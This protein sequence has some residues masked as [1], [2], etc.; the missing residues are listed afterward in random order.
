MNSWNGEEIDKDINQK[1]SVNIG[2]EGDC[3]GWVYWLRLNMTKESVSEY[4]NRLPEWNE[5]KIE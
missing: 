3:L 5:K 4:V 2:T 1:I